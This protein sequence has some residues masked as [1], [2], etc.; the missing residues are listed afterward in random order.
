M[1]C[2]WGRCWLGTRKYWDGHL[3]LCPALIF[4]KNRRVKNKM[5][6]GDGVS[7]A[8]FTYPI[9]QAWDWWHLFQSKGIHMQ[10]G[11]SDQFGNIT[12]GI[13]AVKHIAKNHHDPVMREKVAPLGDPFGFTVPLLTTSSGD[14]FGKSAGNAIW[15]DSEYTSTFDLY[16]YFLRTSDADVGKFLKMFTFMPID[17][18]DNLVK[19]HLEAPELRKAQHALARSFVE[20]AHGAHEAKIA[21]EQH[22]FLFGKQPEEPLIMEV[23]ADADA[24]VGYT[25]LNNKPRV[26]VQ[27]P[28]SVVHQLSIGRILY[29][30]GLAASASEGHRLAQQSAV[31]IGGMPHGKKEPMVDGFVNWTKI[32]P[33]KPE[34]TSKFLVHGDLLMLRKGKHNIRVIQVVP[35][36]EY[37]SSGKT[38][39]G[40]KLRQGPLSNLEMRN[41]KVMEN[42]QTPRGKIEEDRLD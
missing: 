6:K 4:F 9:M 17:A 12:A 33:W 30:S 22:R 20:L 7:F 37:H 21:E 42:L 40:Q 1:E 38:Y 13:D 23:P 5:N 15:L 35:D 24:K 19:E 41:R 14:K 18:I 32:K 2:D 31:F 3:L 26:N 27:L 11:G 10:I 34:D 39:P 8:E 36:E 25:T 16:G 29:A 28:H